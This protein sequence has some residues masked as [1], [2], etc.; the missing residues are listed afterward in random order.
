MLDPV[1]RSGAYFDPKDERIG[2]RDKVQGMPMQPSL[3]YDR[4][5][6][7]LVGARAD[8][9]PSRERPR[10][11]EGVQR[12]LSRRLHLFSEFRILLLHYGR[13]SSAR[14]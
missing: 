2:L 9:I 12:Q 8:T 13:Q 7:I 10:S 4:L 3:G 14:P 1:C 5:F 11:F 6:A